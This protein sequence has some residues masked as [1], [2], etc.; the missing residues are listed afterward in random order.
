MLTRLLL[1][2]WWL[3][4]SGLALAASAVWQSGKL[5]ADR[6]PWT[7]SKGVSNS[8]AESSRSAAPACVV[9]EGRVVAYPGA[10]VVVG[11]EI[12]GRI[13]A[14]P[15]QE[16]SVV[17]R[18]DL[19]AELSADDLRAF[20]DEAV[21]RAQEAEAELRF[22][23]REMGREEMLITRRAGTPQ[24]LDGHRRSYD[25]ARARR[26]AALATRDRYDALIAKTRIVAPIDGVVTARHAH[27]GET[28]EVSSQI[29]TIANLS[30]LRIEAEVDEF[31]TSRVRLGAA[32]AITAEGFD[33]QA[34]TGRVEE[35]PDSVVPRRLRPEDPGRPIDARVLP[36]KIAFSSANPLKLGQRVEAAITQVGATAQNSPPPAIMHD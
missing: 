10:E 3:V 22:F 2:K 20:R 31:D 35:I 14:L 32:V 17:R 30:L 13:L 23:E 11:T 15:V 4:V 34:W 5:D 19:I 16:K 26:A 27:P 1:G 33:S 24:T 36:V 8:A 28:V 12:A 25:T 29:V 18:G 21:A 7:A 9:A 6:L